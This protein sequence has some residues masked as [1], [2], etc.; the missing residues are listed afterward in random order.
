[1]KNIEEDKT[2]FAENLLKKYGWKEGEGIG[3]TNK[4]IA[5]PIKASLKFNNTGVSYI[6]PETLKIFI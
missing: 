4:G 1:M 5:M 3:K 2:K 6:L